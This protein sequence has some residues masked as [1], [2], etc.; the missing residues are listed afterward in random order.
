MMSV[1]RIGPYTVMLGDQTHNDLV[2]S[3]DQANRAKLLTR[4]ERIDPM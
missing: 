2:G 3:A 4:S 1:V